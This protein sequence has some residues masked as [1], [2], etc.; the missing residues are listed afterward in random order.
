L[1]ASFERKLG[2]YDSAPVDLVWDKDAAGNERLLIVCA[3]GKLITISGR[4][5]FAHTV[6]SSKSKETK[7]TTSKKSK[8]ADTLVAK[9]PGNQDIDTYNVLKTASVNKTTVVDKAEDDDDEDD[10]VENAGSNVDDNRSPSKTSKKSRIEEMSSHDSEDDTVSKSAQKASI[11]KNPF[12]MDEAEDGEEDE[13]SVGNAGF[14]GDSTQSPVVKSNEK[15][16][17]VNSFASDDDGGDHPTNHSIGDGNDQDDQSDDGLDDVSHRGQMTMYQP[18]IKL[19]EPQIA[20]VPSATPTDLARRFMCWNH[21]GAITH[22]QGEAG[23]TR[24]SIDIHFTD[25]AF[26]RPISFTDN[27]GFILGC[28]GEEGG[29]FATDVEEDEE[30][31]DLNQIVKGLKMSEATKAAL[32][33]SHKSRMNNDSAKPTGSNIYFHRFETFAN[34]RDKDWYL[35]LPDGERAI[36]CATGEGWAAV[37]TS[38]RFLRIFSTGGNQG[39][40]L[41]LPGEPVTMVGRQRFLAAFYHE[42]QPLPDS[43][44]KLGYILF[45]AHA[46]RVIARG[47]VSCI[48]SGCSLTW[49]GF[50]NDGSLLAMDS[51]GML[52]M[53]ATAGPPDD[54]S[55]NMTWEW[56]PMLDTVGHRKSNEDSFWPVYVYEGKLVCVPL[57]GGVKHPDASRRPVTTNIGFRLPFARGGIAKNNA[58][59]ELSI[60]ANVALCQKKAVHSIAGDDDDKFDKEYLALSAQVVSFSVLSYLTKTL[61]WVWAHFRFVLTGQ[62]HAENVPCCGRSWQVGTCARPC[63]PVT[64][65]SQLQSGSAD[66]G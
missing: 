30:D 53:L 54:G 2:E 13:D 15:L 44:Q 33:K 50:S 62:G 26:R 16:E 14:D 32:K 29:I 4:S 55:L 59:E 34:V 65:R 31:E 28:L 37:M 22:L 19:P 63:W 49:A 52:S 43:T 21:M 46:N 41:W 39:H 48:S 24:S 51:D 3:D 66:C 7:S 38:R 23:V 20:F 8:M 18:S 5:N 27:M 60:R 35:T 9:K 10:S 42:A 40:V 56:M 58:F 6:T 57:K 45:D 12:V 64:S 36:G 61:F 1:K 47:S 25:S 11:K 17:R